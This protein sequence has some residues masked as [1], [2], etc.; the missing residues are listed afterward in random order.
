[1]TVT[2]TIHQPTQGNLPTEKLESSEREEGR[3]NIICKAD[4]TCS[5]EYSFQLFLFSDSSLVQMTL[6]PL[7]GFSIWSFNSP[8]III[9]GPLPSV[10]GRENP[11]GWV[12][13]AENGFPLW[14]SLLWLIDLVDSQIADHLLQI[15]APVTVLIAIFI[16]INNN[17]FF[18]FANFG[19][20]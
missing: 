4:I 18:F 2:Q 13:T 9:K 3:I 8:S 12:I 16:L 11:W 7:L 10:N 19:N 17:N 14:W 1:M 20:V 15:G 6:E 5:G